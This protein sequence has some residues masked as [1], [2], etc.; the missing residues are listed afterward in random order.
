M[1]LMD[2]DYLPELIIHSH[3]YEKGHRNAPLK[4]FS[5]ENGVSALVYSR[6]RGRNPINAQ[7]IPC[8]I[9]PSLRVP[10]GTP[11]KFEVSDGALFEGPPGGRQ[12]SHGVH[13]G[14][15]LRLQQLGGPAL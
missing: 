12:H 10:S 2:G 5:P 14:V 15:R 13:R 4:E 11:F 1:K 9:P 6:R 8:V 3:E 7:A